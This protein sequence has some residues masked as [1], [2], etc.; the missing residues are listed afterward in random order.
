MC[1]NIL[2][3]AIKIRV[4]STEFICSRTRKNNLVLTATSAGKAAQHNWSTVCKPSP[5]TWFTWAHLQPSALQR[6]FLSHGQ[7]PTKSKGLRLYMPCRTETYVSSFFRQVGT[8][9]C[10]LYHRLIYLHQDKAEFPE[11]LFLKSQGHGTEKCNL[12]KGERKGVAELQCGALFW[13]CTFLGMAARFLR[14]CFLLLAVGWKREGWGDCLS[15]KSASARRCGESFFTQL[16]L[17]SP[18]AV[19]KAACPAPFWLFFWSAGSHS[20]RSVG[21]DQRDLSQHL[22]RIV[23]KG[24]RLSETCFWEQQCR[25]VY[26]ITVY[27]KIRGKSALAASLLA[28]EI[29]SLPMS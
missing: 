20:S 26:Q 17:C 28:W 29:F 4:C 19:W 13:H 1:F 3:N 2:R 15:H 5:E 16:P 6:D 18:C 9:F 22:W 8:V 27:L 7:S 12:N 11:V 14:F 23:V 21:T 25:I 24:H 10:I